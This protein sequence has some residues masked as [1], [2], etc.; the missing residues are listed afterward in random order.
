MMGQGADANAQDAR[1][2]T[3]LMISALRN[4][5]LAAQELL[6]HGASPYIENQASTYILGEG[7]LKYTCFNQFF[8]SLAVW[9]HCDDV[10]TAWQIH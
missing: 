3:P 7:F 9:L 4:D 1:G 5:V 8:A 6:K 10:G 2:F